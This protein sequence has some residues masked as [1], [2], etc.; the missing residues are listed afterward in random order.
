[1]EAV[2]PV[3]SSFPTLRTQ[4]FSHLENDASLAADKDLAE[5]RRELAKIKLAAY[6]Q[7]IARGFNRNVRTRTFV[8]E[9]VLRKVLLK[10]KKQKLMPNWEGPYRI[11]KVA[12]KG[13]YKLEEMDGTPISKPWNALNLRKYYH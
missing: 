6:Q 11:V 4:H 9:L 13:T 10:S 1:M 7:E 8:P 5:E 3:Q 12:G 2:I